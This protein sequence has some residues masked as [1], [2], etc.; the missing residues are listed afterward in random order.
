MPASTRSSALS[1]SKLIG[2]AICCFP[3]LYVVKPGPVNLGSRWTQSPIDTTRVTLVR[4]PS[5]HSPFSHPLFATP[6]NTP[7]HFR[8]VATIPRIAVCFQIKVGCRPSS[9]PRSR[10]PDRSLGI[11]SR[12]KYSSLLESSV[13]SPYSTTG[14][15]SAAKT[16]FKIVFLGK[17]GVGKTSVTLRFCRD[18]FQTGTEATI[19]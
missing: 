15:Q 1:T 11:L 2:L 10:L 12:S 14:G 16:N 8:W 4:P 9:S 3:P 7:V 6:P 18:T 17:S 5:V 13:I 19:G